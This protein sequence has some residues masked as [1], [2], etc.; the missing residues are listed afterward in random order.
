M[1][2]FLRC[3]SFRSVPPLHAGGENV[4]LATETRLKIAKLVVPP[5]C[6][7]PPHV[8]A[9]PRQAPDRKPVGPPHPRTHEQYKWV[10]GRVTHL[11]PA[12]DPIDL[13]SQAEIEIWGQRPGKFG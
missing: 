2:I 9:Q 12:R 3:F 10:E 7:T 6:R 8:P 13:R 1:D 11:P 5:H 4:R